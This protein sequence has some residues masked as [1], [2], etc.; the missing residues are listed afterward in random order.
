MPNTAEIDSTQADLSATKSE[1]FVQADAD[2]NS[3]GFAPLDDQLLSEEFESMESESPDASSPKSEQSN[4]DGLAASD[5]PVVSENEL[6]GVDDETDLRTHAE[7]SNQRADGTHLELPAFDPKLSRRRKLQHAKRRLLQ[8]LAN[9][10]VSLIASTASLLLGF[11]GS[12]WFSGNSEAAP[13]VVANPQLTF[14]ATTLRRS[15]P[16]A[17]V[18]PFEN[19]DPNVIAIGQ[20]LFHDS[21]LSG[22]GKLSCVT[23]H[24]LEPAKGVDSSSIAAVPIA[25][26][27]PALRRDVPAVFNAP[28]NFRLGWDGSFES[29]ESFLDDHFSKDGYMATDWERVLKV[30]REDP[31]YFRSFQLHMNEEPNEKLV[32]TALATYERSLV[33]VNSP[34]DQWLMGNDQALSGDAIA[35]YYLFKQFNCISCHQGAGVGG[36]MLR[37]I[38]SL[39]D[40]LSPEAK[41]DFGL[42]TT[43]GRER[44]RYL[45][46]V[47]SLRNVALTAPYF[48]DGSAATLEQAVELMM[49]Q[50]LGLEP[51]PIDVER[52]ITFL[53]SLTGQTLEE[54]QSR[55]EV[56]KVV[57]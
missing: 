27:T 11:V 52:L 22:T 28:L 12:L 40:R 51:N 35:G 30:T 48:H 5:S 15:E 13:Q 29:L 23:C 56:Q 10:K 25:N 39:V 6:G 50:Q 17:T 33:R 14:V 31:L 19:L 8:A 37:S 38:D 49:Q 57:D 32:R 16:I 18:T 26:A 3:V 1:G 20:R 9:H 7:S 44:D 47:P 42:F 53:Q 21:S 36:S 34:F 55:S 24:R 4:S 43:T 41:N 54:V 45:F 2:E 46:R